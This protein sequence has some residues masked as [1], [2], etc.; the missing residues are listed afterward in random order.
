MDEAEIVDNEGDCWIRVKVGVGTVV[1]KLLNNNNVMG[2]RGE[3]D[4]GFRDLRAW[5][6]KQRW[7]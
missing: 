6:V 3:G 5:L 4:T 7:S 2:G 1:S